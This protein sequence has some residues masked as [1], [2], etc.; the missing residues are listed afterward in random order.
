MGALSPDTADESSRKTHSATWASSG[1][2]E[3]PRKNR[4][5]LPR[6]VSVS[7]SLRFSRVR[8]NVCLFIVPIV[9]EFRRIHCKR[10]LG[11]EINARILHQPLLRESLRIPPN[12]ADCS[13]ANETAIYLSCSR[14]Y[15]TCIAKISSNEIS[16]LLHA[17]PSPRNSREYSAPR[18]RARE[19]E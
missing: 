5:I 14:R 19:A 8:R 15:L 2:G 17:C 3:S 16:S 4:E 12:F 10:S 7:D 13:A 9:E 11:L 1:R 18:S 6:S